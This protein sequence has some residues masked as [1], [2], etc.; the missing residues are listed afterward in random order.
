MLRGYHGIRASWRRCW[1][2]GCAQPLAA[3]LTRLCP[4]HLA[5]DDRLAA[6]F[7][8]AQLEFHFAAKP[9]AVAA[10]AF[11]PTP[12]YQTAFALPRPRLRGSR[13]PL[14]ETDQLRKKTYRELEVDAWNARKQRLVDKRA[15]AAARAEQRKRIVAFNRKIDAELEEQGW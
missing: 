13:K 14:P 12:Q 8:A 9:K 15:I 3:L 7:K 5:E 2:A 11:H 4:F 1:W 6:A 10:P